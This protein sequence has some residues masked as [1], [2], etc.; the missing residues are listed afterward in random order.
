V[1]RFMETRSFPPPHAVPPLTLLGHFEALSLPLEDFDDGIG[2]WS[3]L[4]IPAAVETAP[5][6]QLRVSLPGF[7]LAFHRP[8]VHDDPLLLFRQPD[9]DTAAEALESLGLRTVSGLGGFGTPDHR[10][11]T[12]PE[13]MPLVLFA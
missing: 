12:S 8:G 13:R 6:K 9:L 2:F 4:G 1:L 10:I 3:R 5:W 7:S 11:L